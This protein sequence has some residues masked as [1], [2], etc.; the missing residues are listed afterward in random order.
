MVYNQG[1]QKTHSN[2]QPE[3]HEIVIGSFMRTTGSLT[4]SNN[5]DQQFFDLRFLFIFQK[6]RTIRQN[7]FFNKP[8]PSLV[9]TS[10]VHFDS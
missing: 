8:Y 4:F 5:W 2:N 10:G 3:N 1:S 7:N 6:P 9:Y